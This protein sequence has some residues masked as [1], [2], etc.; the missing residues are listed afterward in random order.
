MSRIT[1]RTLR[2]TLPWQQFLFK[3]PIYNVISMEVRLISATGLS[4]TADFI[5]MNCP[6]AART[7]TTLSEVF[8]EQQS[9]VWRESYPIP[10][11][12]SNQLP[13]K[14]ILIQSGNPAA[15]AIISV[16]FQ[17]RVESPHVITPGFNILWEVTFEIAGPDNLLR[18][19]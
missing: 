1:S 18:G 4:T 7:N 2:Q 16:D 3:Q 5:W 6:E 14:Q 9:E 12:R 19:Y 15:N 17:L 13:P 10:S 8:S 11:S